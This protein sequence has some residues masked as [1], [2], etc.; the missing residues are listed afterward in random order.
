MGNSCLL[1]AAEN[2]HLETIKCLIE[3]GCS[4]LEKNH[5]GDSCLLL[6]ARN[7]R[8][9][10]VKWLIEN[11]RPNDERN[12]DKSNCILE[13]SIQGDIQTIKWLLTKGFSL[14][15]TNR[16]GT[17]V[18]NASECDQLEAVCWMLSNGSSIDEDTAKID[19]CEEILKRKNLFHKVVANFKT[20]SA[21]KKILFNYFFPYLKSEIFC[22]NKEF[23]SRNLPL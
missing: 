11:G 7:K 13:A 20:K 1:L 4:I 14:L 18:M 23:S 3:N 16:F 17:C 2:G 5:K 12:N 19:S 21:N 10:T 15:D 22:K 8:L 6:A 9:E